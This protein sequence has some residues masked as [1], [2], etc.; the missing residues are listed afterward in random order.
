MTPVPQLRTYM[1]RLMRIKTAQQI[2]R[3]CVVELGCGTGRNIHYLSEVCKIPESNIIGFD[4]DCKGLDRCIER[5]IGVGTWPLKR[6]SVD[7]ILCLYVLMFLTEEELANVFSEIRR[8]SKP[9]TELLGSL[10]PAKNA[11]W[12]SY[13]LDTLRRLITAALPSTEWQ[14]VF[15]RKDE[16]CYRRA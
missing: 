16:F 7:I 13:E 4:L 9:G 3:L 10:Y 12:E 8:I 2:S 15:Q 1:E 5:N 6:H 14:A 11:Y